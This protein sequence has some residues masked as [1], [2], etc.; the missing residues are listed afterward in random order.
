MDTGLVD[1]LKIA[2]RGLVASLALL[3]GCERKDITVHTVPPE[4]EPAAKSAAGASM[5]AAGGSQFAHPAWKVPAGW[6]TQAGD[7]MR[8]GLFS[9]KGA[10]NQTA[11]VTVIPLAGMAGGELANVNRWRSQVGL[12]AVA[13]AQLAA[14]QEKVQIGK[15]PASLYDFVGTAPGADGKTRIMVAASIQ[16]GTSWFFKM[17]GADELVQ[18]QK[19]EFK[20]F[21][22]SVS[23]DAAAA[24]AA[25][26][27]PAAFTPPPGVMPP[28][29]APALAKPAWKVPTH[30]KEQPPGKM[31]LAKFTIEDAAAKAE[32]TVSAFPGAVG[33]LFA[34]VNRWRGQ[35][36]LPLLGKQE[37][38]TN[39]I[40]TLS[41]K[42][43]EGQWVDMTA[44]N[45]TNRLM[46]FL[47]T[48]EG[49][50]WFYKLSGEANLAGREKDVLVRFVESAF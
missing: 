27:S 11:Q 29:A 31:Q 1:L 17:T 13:E 35:L 7:Q 22:K 18:Q 12:E 41:I 44:S 37:E 48:R 42:G 4:K 25:A 2:G 49:Q 8:V 20:E 14:L 21:L 32:V 19:P 50:T 9:I 5:P 10:S 36:D 28:M 3:A 23:F 38:L 47:A 24:Q 26:P 39:Y 33:G 45:K 15:E 30:W 16:G 40:S 34:N 46:V 43:V 6:E